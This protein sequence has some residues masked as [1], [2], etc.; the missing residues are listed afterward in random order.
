M[1]SDDPRF[2]FLRQPPW[3]RLVSY[4]EGDGVETMCWQPDPDIYEWQAAAN[5]HITVYRTANS[6][7]RLTG[8]GFVERDRV[9]VRLV[10]KT[11]RVYAVTEGHA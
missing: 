2:R 8:Q 3:E 4:V 11:G 9:G 5:G 1:T 10:A 6:D 7:L